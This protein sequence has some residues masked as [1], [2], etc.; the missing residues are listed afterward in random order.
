MES[1]LGS[2][3]R[4]RHV[5]LVVRDMDKAV[6]QYESL[7]GTGVFRPE[8]IMD[9]STFS[10]YKVYGKTPTT[11]HKSRFKHSEI[12]PDKLDLE[13]ISPIEGEPIYKDFLERQG[14][15][16]HHIA[17]A[18]DDLDAETAKLVARGIPVLTS[19]KRP[20][21][22]GFAYFDFGGCLIELI[23]TVKTSS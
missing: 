4:F 22:R 1:S 16:L 7:L 23:G 18:V 5:A 21:G 17:F 12:G 3:W 10:D 14:E 8:T 11:V 15:G 2:N 20:N 6:K 13:F 19:V 9:S